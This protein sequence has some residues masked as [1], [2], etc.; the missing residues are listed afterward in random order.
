MGE[1]TLAPMRLVFR[2]DASMNLGSGHVMRCL[3]IAE[4]AVSRGTQCVL[5][6]SLG[7]VDWL[8]ERITSIGI[9]LIPESKFFPVDNSDVLIIDSYTLPR[10][11]NFIS[12]NKWGSVVAIADEATPPYEAGL[13]IHPGLDGAWFKGNQENFLFGPQFIPIRKSIKKSLR[14]NITELKKIVVFGGGTDT[15]RF[16]QEI[17]RQLSGLSGYEVVS[18]F[19]LE[20]KGI[21][22]LDSRF[23][24]YP[25][26][27]ALDTELIEADLVFTT[28]SSS[29]LEIVAREIPLGVACSI[30][31]QHTYFQALSDSKIAV[32]IGDRTSTGYWE[33]D[34]EA[35]RRLVSDHELRKETR[36]A[37]DGFIDLGG[38][39]RIVDAVIRMQTVI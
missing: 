17:G 24:V 9:N 3:A 27:S 39:K 32:Q 22:A 18:F 13:V 20:K 34:V 7:G 11:D 33:F 4:E 25:F 21:E 10:D 2:A 12:A 29:S 37:C 30:A 6:G 38:S 19:S 28:A 8:Q 15:Y 31:N 5:V 23:K 16:A 35:I 36:M 26:G 14:R 1:H